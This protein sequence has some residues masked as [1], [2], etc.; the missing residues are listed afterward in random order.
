MKAW[1]R[2]RNCDLCSGVLLNL[3]IEPGYA[4]LRQIDDREISGKNAKNKRVSGT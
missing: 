3:Q 4:W 2:S 1:K